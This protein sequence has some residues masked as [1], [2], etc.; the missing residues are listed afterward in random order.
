MLPLISA[1]ACSVNSPLVAGGLTSNSNLCS[2]FFQLCQIHNRQDFYTPA[3]TTGK[4]YLSLF[5]WQL[6]L[7]TY[8]PL[9]GV[10]VSKYNHL[11]AEIDGNFRCHLKW[12][13][14]SPYCC[15]SPP[16]QDGKRLTIELKIKLHHDLARGLRQ[17]STL[18][19]LPCTCPCCLFR[20]ASTHWCTHT[21]VGT[22]KRI[23][24]QIGFIVTQFF[25][26]QGIFSG[27]V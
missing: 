3:V 9:S 12:S 6:L 19:D 27:R 20:W 16:A 18:P 23:G 5:D 13:V 25:H 14:V 2:V 8:T 1:S 10:I 7:Y 26:N 22:G 21:L 17:K 15:I 11:F 4:L 24:L